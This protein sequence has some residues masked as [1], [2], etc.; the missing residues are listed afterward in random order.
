MA[1][2]EPRD[3]NAD[4]RDPKTWRQAN[5][6]FG[7]LVSAEDFESTMLRTPESEFRT[8][9]CNQFT[10]GLQAWLPAGAWDACADP[11]VE[12][13]PGA[14][15]VI[16]FD[17]SFNNDS[18]AIVIATCGETPHLEVAACWERPVDAQPGWT[19]PIGDV[20]EEIREVARRF[21]VREIAADPF[22]WAR[23]MEVLGEE[24]LPVEAFSPTPQRMTPATQRF[25]EAVM[26]RQLT[27]SGDRRLARHIDS[28]VLKIDARGQR[29]VKESKHSGRR[30]DLA[31][32]RSD[33][34]RPGIGDGCAPDARDLLTRMAP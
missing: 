17:G 6:G 30:I 33:G 11:H 25:Y 15:V 1:W 7:D 31:V 12:I 28:A 32:G 22:R 8:K 2:W 21:Y 19:V 10:S 16:G 27:H 13:E 5:P 24:G 29:I 26:N 23:S 18:T 9:R 20:E 14:E 3:P 4:H 34:A